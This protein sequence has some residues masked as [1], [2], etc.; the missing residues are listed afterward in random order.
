MFDVS[1]EGISKIV[2]GG[3][4]NTVEFISSWPSEQKIAQVISSFANRE[5]GIIL[6]GVSGDGHPH[7][8]GIGDEEYN[9]LEKFIKDI[10]SSILPWPVEIGHA[11]LEGYS[12]IYVIIDKAP[13]YY[14]PIM[15]SRGEAYQRKGASDVL[16]PAYQSKTLEKP[17]VKTDKKTKLTVFVAMSFR[18][19]EE[20]SLVDYFQAMRR[21]VDATGLFIELR[22]VDLVEG[23]YEISQHIMDEIDK[24]NIVIADFTLTSRNVY[25]ELGYARGR[26][27]RIIQTAR[28][29]TMLEFDI[30]NWRTI[31]YRNATELEK[32]LISELKTAYHE[33]I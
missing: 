19:E 13:R 18:E 28:K 3:E 8:G 32:K 7:L 26:K 30:R 2:S 27:I 4:S 5:G 31:F 6:I 9:S 33:I 10:C 25:F 17:K 23:D 1:T 14:Y 21:A 22:R 16:I 12:I 11:L 20:P 29:G 15:T 24:A